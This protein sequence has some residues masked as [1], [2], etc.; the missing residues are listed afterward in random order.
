MKAIAIIPARMAASRFPGK[1]MRSIIGMPMVEHCYH[2][3]CLALGPDSVYVAT[4]DS[5]IDSHIKSLGGKSIMTSSQH[6]RATTRTAEALQI[7]ETMQSAVVD[8]VVMMQGDE[9]LVPPHVISET[10]SHFEDVTVDVVNIMSQIYT[11]KEFN[12]R[13]NVKVVV[14]CNN[15]ALYFSREAIP[16]GGIDKHVPIYMQTGIIAFRKAALVHFNQIPEA[17]LEICE[18]VDMNRLLENGKP[19]RQRAGPLWKIESVHRQYVFLQRTGRQPSRV[20]H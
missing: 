18:S 4:C 13:N 20:L 10:L 19:I 12:D 15:D 16:F 9:P 5:E 11:K 6:N 14:N 3:A 8:V 1:P 7:I 17:E 2:R